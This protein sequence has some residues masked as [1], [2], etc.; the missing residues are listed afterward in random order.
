MILAVEV[1]IYL[2]MLL[3]CFIKYIFKQVTNKK[4]IP[5]LILKNNLYGLDIDD[6]A[7]QLSILSVL[8]KAREYDKQIF[9]KDIVR[10]INVMNI[11]ESNCISQSIIDN[12]SDENSKKQAQ[13]LIDN[14]KNAKEIG[15]LLI[16]EDKDYS[17][18]EKNIYGDTTTIFGI[19]L[20]EKVI[21]NNKNCQDLIKKI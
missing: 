11:Q 2:Y 10:D 1:V 20:R 6:R 16:L 3:K 12:I 13:Y 8:L 4:D 9:S 7:G 15:S 17:E 14:F 5:E 19:E 21:T 18:L